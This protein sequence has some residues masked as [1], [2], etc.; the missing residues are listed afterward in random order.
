[1]TYYAV[2]NFG[3]PPS[4]QLFDTREEAENFLHDVFDF[5]D[6]YEII[7]LEEVESQ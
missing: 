5:R 2:L 3:S 6:E 1:M 7:E 4:H